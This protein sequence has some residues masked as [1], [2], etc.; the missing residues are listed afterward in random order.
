MSRCKGGVGL[1][2]QMVE[3]QMISQQVNNGISIQSLQSGQVSFQGKTGV[4]QALSGI[5]KGLVGAESASASTG[6]NS[7]AS[8]EAT[9]SVSNLLGVNSSDTASST[10]N[11][12]RANENRQANSFNPLD[13]EG[14]ANRDIDGSFSGIS[15][16]SRDWLESVFSVYR[17]EN[18]GQSVALQNYLNSCNSVLSDFVP[19]KVDLFSQ[20]YQNLTGIKPG[21]GFDPSVSSQ[22]CPMCGSSLSNSKPGSVAYFQSTAPTFSNVEM[23]L[24]PA[25]SFGSKNIVNGDL[26]V[27]GANSI[28]YEGL[29]SLYQNSFTNINNQSGGVSES[30]PGFDASAYM[31]QIQDM[32]G[33]GYTSMASD[34]MEACGL[35]S[36]STDD[37]NAYMQEVRTAAMSTSQ[38]VEKYNA[39][40]TDGILS[41][42]ELQAMY[43]KAVSANGVFASSFLA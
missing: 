43:E 18:S 8:L 21:N 2:L 17:D 10:D 4:T 41:D 6:S 42:S 36:I 37:I 26:D 23:F 29:A 39:Q 30:I 20:Q 25:G 28:A 24:P 31:Q 11:I 33:E 5:S 16:Y 15:D 13:P 35:S 14:N 9:S 40:M 22:S 34:Y 27:F 38:L 3:G 19:T 32:Y 12:T 7:S 1:S